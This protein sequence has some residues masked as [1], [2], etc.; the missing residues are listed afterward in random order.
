MNALQIGN[1]TCGTTCTVDT[2][3]NSRH[4]LEKG[5]GGCELDRKSTRPASGRY[6][7][8]GAMPSN[9]SS[10]SWMMMRGVTII[11]RL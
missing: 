3:E 9:C 8:G 7:V 11:I 1:V 5:Y 2:N 10:S 4:N 6:G